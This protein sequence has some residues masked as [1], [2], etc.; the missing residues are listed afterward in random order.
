MISTEAIFLWQIIQT[1]SNI[2]FIDNLNFLD[3]NRD[4]HSGAIFPIYTGF[5]RLGQNV[6]PPVGILSPSTGRRR[7]VN[8]T[9]RLSAIQNTSVSDIRNCLSSTN[10]TS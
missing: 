6:A 1:I 4:I 2:G 3:H 9:T 8:Y 7:V 5:A 10:H